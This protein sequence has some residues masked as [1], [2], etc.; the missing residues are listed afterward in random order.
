MHKCKT[1]SCLPLQDLTANHYRE[2]TDMTIPQY[3]KDR[4]YVAKLAASSPEEALRVA[5]GIT[6]PWFR[7]QALAYVAH[8]C[9]DDT[10]KNELLA[11]SF[12]AA[13]NAGDANRIVSASAWPLKVL[14]QS[15]QGEQLEVK[16]DHLLSL[17]QNEPSPVRRADALNLMLGAVVCGPTSCF[18]KV[19]EDRK[20]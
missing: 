17:I 2:G 8:H 7:C 5:R 19:L 6:E 11:E 20:S 13:L 10:K 14:C 15:R 18:L 16:V 1:W 12:A 4:D 3:T 9:P